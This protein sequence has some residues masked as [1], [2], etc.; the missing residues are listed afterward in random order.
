MVRFWIMGQVTQAFTV[1][2]A[3][4]SLLEA[5]MLVSLMVEDG[6]ETQTKYM[7][8]GKHQPSYTTD[9]DLFFLID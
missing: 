7:N 6:D 8:G 9:L 5:S 4:L 1:T 3:R 2:L